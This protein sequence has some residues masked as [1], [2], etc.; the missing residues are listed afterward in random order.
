MF[1]RMRAPGVR[2]AL[3]VLLGS[4]ACSR[5]TGDATDGVDPRLVA[6]VNEPLRAIA[7]R[8]AG[9][10]FDVEYP[11]PP[12]ED[13]AF[14]KP[15]GPA[16][17]R[18]RAAAVILLNGAGYAKWTG[19]AALP[20]AR[21]VD[22]S[23]GFSDRLLDDEGAVT[24]SHGPDGEHHHGE[25]AFT[26]WIDPSLLAEHAAAVRS[27]LAAARPDAAAAIESRY[28]A[29]RAEIETLDASVLALSAERR[30]VPMLASHPV[31]Q[32]LARRLGLDLRSVHLEP[33]VVP[34]EAGWAAL[35]AL[36]FVHPARL[37][38]WEG[39]PA[40]E[41]R[42]GLAARGVGVVRFDPCGAAS[43]AGGFLAAQRANFD[44]LAA[45]LAELP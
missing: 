24:H 41:T 19:Q 4:A 18:Y 21:S 14:W 20:F 28:D 6:T 39:E 8:I 40:P 11:G 13:P 10:A 35:D 2:F 37:M 23:A 45:A 31:Y 5:P 22:T 12:D 3:L 30:A 34:D 9:D 15:D 29:L 25:T 43:P 32:Y 36:L 16:L 1:T 44:R 7:A 26:T 27:A 42:A 33:D 38:L 17:D